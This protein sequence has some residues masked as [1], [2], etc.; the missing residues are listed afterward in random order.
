MLEESKSS[1]KNSRKEKKRGREDIF[2]HDF[3]G[4]N[5]NF[6][7]PKTKIWKINYCK[8]TVKLNNIDNSKNNDN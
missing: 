8:N 4:W 7:D 6:Y 5:W 1:E 3:G 2:F